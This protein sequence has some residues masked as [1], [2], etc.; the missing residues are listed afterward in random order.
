[1]LERRE[2]GWGP[3]PESSS[4]AIGVGRK[5]TCEPANSTEVC[6]LP[7]PHQ[8]LFPQS[9]HQHEREQ[10]AAERQPHVHATGACAHLR[11]RIWGALAV[12]RCSGVDGAGVFFSRGGS[13]TVRLSQVMPDAALRFA[14][15][16][17]RL[18]G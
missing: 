13:H 2:A 1:M 17:A 7:L 9:Q 18:V 14:F 10:G 8:R 11:G 15:V 12:L 5:D 4:A 6:P 3:P 16:L